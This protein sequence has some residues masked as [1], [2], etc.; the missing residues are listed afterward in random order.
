MEKRYREM[1]E[2]RRERRRFNQRKE[3]GVSRQ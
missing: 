3:A 1:D 2:R